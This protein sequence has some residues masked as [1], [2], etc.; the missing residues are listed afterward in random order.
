MAVLKTLGSRFGRPKKVEAHYFAEAVY[1]A[2]Q[3]EQK[4]CHNGLLLVI[5]SEDREVP[6][7]SLHITTATALSVQAGELAGFRSA[8]MSSITLSPSGTC[9]HAALRFCS[10]WKLLAPVV[11]EC[12]EAGHA[13]HQV[14]GHVTSISLRSPQGASR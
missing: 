2:W 8:H 5:A 11:F 4:D 9:V 1:N 14:V 7:C 3:M 13:N 12:L 10:T 6:C